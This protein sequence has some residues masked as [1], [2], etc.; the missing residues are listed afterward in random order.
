MNP[1]PPRFPAPVITLGDSASILWDM[2]RTGGAADDLLPLVYDELHSLAGQFLRRER[3]A[4]TLQATALVNE[5]YLRLAQGSA[6]ENRLHFFRVAARAMRAVL[7]NHVRDRGRLKRGGDR[8]RV[9]LGAGEQRV[10]GPLTDLLDLDTALDELAGQDA[11]LAQIVELRFFSGLTVGEVA[12]LLGV[13]VP[14]VERRWRVARAFLR[15]NM[16][17]DVEG[18]S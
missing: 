18:G 11:E 13:S 1:F 6:F 15:K 3:P 16:R 7:V 14:T 8:A 17:G 12:E 5:A 10:E 9:T 4:H 2:E